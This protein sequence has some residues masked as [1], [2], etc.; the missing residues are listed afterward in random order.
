MMHQSDAT[1]VSPEEIVFQDVD[2]ATLAREDAMLNPARA[3]LGGTGA[4]HDYL[5]KVLPPVQSR[6]RA[7]YL[8]AVAV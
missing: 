4:W 6:P 7:P 2:A 1:P 5:R 8:R 3:F